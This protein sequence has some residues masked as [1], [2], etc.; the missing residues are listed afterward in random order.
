M[1]RLPITYSLPV[2]VIAVNASQHTYIANDSDSWHTYIASGSNAVNIHGGS[3][4]GLVSGEPAVD[5][6]IA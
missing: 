6:N 5:E 2:T 1:N 3:V 4:A